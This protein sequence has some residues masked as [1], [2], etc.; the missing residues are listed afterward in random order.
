MHAAWVGDSRLVVECNGGVGFATE[1]HKPDR[2]DERDRIENGAYGK[3]YMN[4]VWRVLGLAVS[5]SIGD[6]PVKN[7]DI[8]RKNGGFPGRVIADPEYAQYQLTPDN[9]F[10]IIASDG[11]WD[12]V[13][14]HEAISLVKN[15][16][17][18]RGS[19][20]DAARALQDEAIKRGSGDNI[21]IIVSQFN[22]SQK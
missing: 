5:R 15:V 1:D 4:G 8:G 11:L 7:A 16:F 9:N 18:E 14:N 13:K 6:R 10:A 21:T 2:P 19:R 12:A 22:W 3:V 20:D 17:K